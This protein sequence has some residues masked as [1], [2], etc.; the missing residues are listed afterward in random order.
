MVF[1]KRGTLLPLERAIL[2]QAVQQGAAGVYGFALA[3]ALDSDS[4]GD[5]RG[6]VAHGTLYKALDRLRREGYLDAEWED[7]AT[8]AAEG[9]PRRRHYTVTAAGVRALRAAASTV[10]RTGEATA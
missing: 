9:R 3:Q 7:A 6:L 8:A 4:D 5:G 1:R 2:D 10:T